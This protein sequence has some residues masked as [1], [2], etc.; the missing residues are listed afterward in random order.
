MIWD[1]LYIVFQGLP[2]I[3]AGVFLGVIAGALPGFGASNTLVILLP[4]TLILPV[5]SAL[6]MVIGLFVGVR[7]GGATP[8]ILI[9]VPGTASG[10]V[11]ALEGYP[12]RKK[13][14]AGKALGIALQASVL[15]SAVSGVVALIA[16]PTI[17]QVA[18]KFS[19]PEIFALAFFSIAMVGQIASDNMV[20]G[21][22]AGAGG[23]L[24]GSIGVDPMWGIERGTFGFIELYDGIPV[25]AALVGLYAV[26]EVIFLAETK[27]K[28]TVNGT[29][30]KGHLKELWSGCV[31]VIK[32]PV[33]LVRSTLIG[34]FI[35]ALPGA[36]ANI[37][38]F[39]SYQQ[40]VTFSPSPEDQKKFGEGNP[41]GIIA[42]EAADNANASGALVPMMTLGIPGSASTAVML[43][44]MTAHGLNVGPT[45][46]V[47]SPVLAYAT[48]AATPVAALMLF[49]IGFFG[50]FAAVRLVMVPP[51]ILAVIIMIF[52]LA[53]AFAA[54]YL[55]FDIG[56]ALVFGVIGYIMRKEGYPVQAMLIGVI[57]APVVESNFFIGLREGFGSPLIFVT[58]PITLI[59]WGLLIASSIFIA[60][61]KRSAAKR[62][63]SS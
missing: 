63:E 61:K 11:T 6:V 25:I 13:G 47:E 40:A 23:L 21:W 44:I 48:L 4:L 29:P 10:A 41:R 27:I 36:G 9:N 52:A 7:F 43:L 24:I 50:T 3:A 60:K 62:L 39:I 38:S 55:A 59:I 58:R 14:Q 28:P 56:L 53:G 17:A 51:A 31:Y 57:L 54:R 46:F 12:M 49:V 30:H 16:A 5:E 15:G 42:S 2:F 19:A 35:G 26:T 32:R 8:A 20:K 34:T 1:V 33:D 37:A 45:L 22:L 18:L